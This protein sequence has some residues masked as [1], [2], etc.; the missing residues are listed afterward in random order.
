MKRFF[1]LKRSTPDEFQDPHHFRDHLIAAS[2]KPAGETD[3]GRLERNRYL[4][5]GAWLRPEEFGQ[6]SIQAHDHR[7]RSGMRAAYVNAYWGLPHI[8]EAITFRIS[9][10]VAAR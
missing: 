9:L 3:Q 7:N 10:K 6:Y 2:L 5:Q 1:L 8:A 4:L